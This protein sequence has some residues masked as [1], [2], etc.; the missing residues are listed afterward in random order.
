MGV[1]ALLPPPA[2]SPGWLVHV[3]RGALGT[4]C[5]PQ[6]WWIGKDWL[7]ALPAWLQFCVCLT[8]D[9]ML[10]AISVARDCGMILP[11]ERVIVADALPPKDGQTARITWQYADA[12]PKRTEPSPA[13]SLE[14]CG[15]G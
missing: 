7:A 11:P 6:A 14:V 3:P 13:L 10:T 8:G 9:N 5:C 12:F 1:V 4:N 2:R 15:H